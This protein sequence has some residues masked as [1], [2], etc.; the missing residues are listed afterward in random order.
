MV[1]HAFFLEPGF[2]RPGHLDVVLFREREVRIAADAEVGRC[3]TFASPPWRLTAAAKAFRLYEAQQFLLRGD[4]DVNS[5]AYAVGYASATQFSRDYKKLF[6]TPPKK[7]V[8]VMKN[9]VRPKAF[10]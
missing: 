2:E 6:G 7:S 4:G 8:R 10:P 9:H 3:T 5:A 1:G